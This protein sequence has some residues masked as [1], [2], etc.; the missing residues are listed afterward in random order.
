MFESSS[1]VVFRSSTYLAEEL[2]SLYVALPTWTYVAAVYR[3]VTSRA[4]SSLRLSLT[5]F[6]AAVSVC[7]TMPTLYPCDNNLSAQSQDRHFRL[8]AH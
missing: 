7:S 4:K 1:S 3:L 5:F 2:I 6:S 8:R